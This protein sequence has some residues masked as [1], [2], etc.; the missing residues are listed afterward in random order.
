MS[1]YTAFMVNAVAPTFALEWTLLAQGCS[2][3]GGVDEVGRGSWAGPVVAACVVLPAG[4]ESVAALSTV[5]DSKSLPAQERD[6][7]FPVIMRVALAVGIG[8]VSHHA[9]DRLGLGAANRLA[10]CRA[11]Y[12]L[13]EIPDALVIDA[14]RLP[15]LCIP[16]ISIPKAESISLSV[17]AASI[18]AKVIRDRWMV[19]RDAEYPHYGFASHKGYGTARHRR[20]L[21]TYGPCPLHRRSFA[22]IAALPV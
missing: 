2:A 11:V 1:R 15:E 3:V 6:R 4:T 10:M 18:V 12:G 14:V 22:P 13:S 8:S 19:R 20:A 16:Q 17:A 21:E 5:R 9:I 7:L